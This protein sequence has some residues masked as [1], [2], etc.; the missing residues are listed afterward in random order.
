VI[1]AVGYLATEL[2]WT[3]IHR[4]LD[5]R[6]TWDHADDDQTSPSNV[7]RWVDQHK[8]PPEEVS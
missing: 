5:K 3:A 7:A 8:R 6:A 2:F 1:R 4:L